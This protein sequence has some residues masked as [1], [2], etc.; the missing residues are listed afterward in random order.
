MS[1]ASQ[2]LKQNIAEYVIY[3]WQMEDLMRAVYFD[4]DALEEFIR[5]YVPDEK[6]YQ[7]ERAWFDDLI[8]TMKREGVEQRGHITEVHEL[9][10]ELNYLHNTLANMLRDKTYLDLYHKAQPNIKDYLARTD[11]KSTNDI[12]VC[13]TALYGMLLLRLKK[14]TVSDETKEAMQS[15][16]NLLARLAHHYRMMKQGETNFSLN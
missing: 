6:A 3:L 1:L 15:F 4:I 5:T 7:E 8:N 16:S 9:V 14:E 13:L 12:E 11:G 10:F 2:K